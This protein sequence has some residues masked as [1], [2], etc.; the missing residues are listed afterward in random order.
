MRTDLTF[1]PA[2]RYD[3]VTFTPERPARCSARCFGKPLSR[4]WET[5]VP[6]QAAP[7]GVDGILNR[8]V[9]ATEKLKVENFAGIQSIELE[10]RGINVLIGPQAAG[11]SICAKLLYFFKDFPLVMPSTAAAELSNSDMDSIL[12]ERFEELFPAA[13]LAEGA[14]CVEYGVGD[15]FIRVS[16]DSIAGSKPELSYSDYFRNELDGLR[17]DRAAALAGAETPFLAQGPDAGREFLTKVNRDLGGA[18]GFRNVFIPAG[19]SFFA[20]LQSSI[21]TVLQAKVPIDPFLTEFGAL[22][23]RWKNWPS[24]GTVSNG[25]GSTAGEIG[26]IVQDILRG[27]YVCDKGEDFLKHADGR[28]VRIVNSSSGQQE[29]LPLAVILGIVPFLRLGALGYSVFI[30]EP[31][32]HLFPTA[33]K[34][35]VELIATVFNSANAQFTITTH[36]PYILT[37]LNNLLQAGSLAKRLTG[38][39]K[40]ELDSIVPPRQALDPDKITTYYLADGGAESICDEESGLISPDAIDD[41]SDEPVDRVRALA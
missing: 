16:R 6:K 1:R 18:I 19:R 11:K 31:E 37:A 35:V 13:A 22:Y 7:E 32:A 41:V 9:I 27:E 15:V 4:N 33:Q 5:L 21:F 25:E 14:F 17:R 29:M 24:L 30:E 36:S 3:S 12:L 20:Y 39:K 40:A 38:E 26:S 28:T 34:Q 2:E 8:R 10:L 23:E